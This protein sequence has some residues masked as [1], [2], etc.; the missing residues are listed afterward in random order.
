MSAQE[1]LLFRRGRF[2]VEIILVRV[3]RHCKHGIRYPAKRMGEHGVDAGAI[4]DHA[5]GPLVR[6]PELERRV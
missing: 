2:P 1:H 4:H 5:L 6:A 3:R